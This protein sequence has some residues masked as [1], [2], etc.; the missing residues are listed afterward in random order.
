[1]RLLAA[2]E[3]LGVTPP[4]TLSAIPEAHARL[5]EAPP[6]TNPVKAAVRAALDDRAT[7]EKVGKVLE[8]AAIGPRSPASPM[9]S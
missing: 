3:K 9:C 4:K 1:V 5:T 7:P 8:A 6:V 2:I